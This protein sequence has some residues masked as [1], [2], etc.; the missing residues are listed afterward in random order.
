MT[1]EERECRESWASAEQRW[2]AGREFP[3]WEDLRGC[4]PH[5]TGALTSEAFVRELRDAWR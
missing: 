5:A 4:A 1:S 2:L 3:D